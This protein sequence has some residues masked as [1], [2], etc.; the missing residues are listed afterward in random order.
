MELDAAVAEQR[1]QQRGLAEAYEAACVELG[2]G[3]GSLDVWKK[4]RLS[5]IFEAIARPG[6]LDLHD[7]GRQAV[8]AFLAEVPAKRAGANTLGA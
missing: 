6:D 3:S 2:I 7:I 5:R 1:D 8:D 4:E